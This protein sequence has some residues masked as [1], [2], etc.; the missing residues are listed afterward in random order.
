M[1]PGAAG[2]DHRIQVAIDWGKLPPGESTG[3]IVVDGIN[4]SV[5]VT[6]KA[7]KADDEQTREA[8]GCFGGLAGPIAFLAADCSA[9]V[10]AGDARWEK[11]PD[12]GRGPS[13]MEVFPVTAGPIEPG[14]PAPRLE[15]PVYFEHAG[16]YEVELITA[17]TLDMI[18]GL[19]QRIAVSIDDQPLKVVRVFNPD[20]PVSYKDVTPYFSRTY[21]KTASNNARIMCF[22]QTVKTAGKHTLKLTMVDPAVVVQKIVVHDGNQPASYFGPPEMAIAH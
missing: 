16:T 14:N 7:I 12:Y 17:P 2:T 19:G 10:P 21:H 1:A 22:T 18:K 8:R 3:S 4:G 15:Y 9:N 20:D 13:A 11:I 5:Q 6:V